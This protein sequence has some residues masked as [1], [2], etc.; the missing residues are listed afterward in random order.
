MKKISLKIPQVSRLLVLLL[1]TEVQIL[2][3]IKRVGL[4]IEIHLWL[5]QVI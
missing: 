3:L 2:A 1:W 4:Y 5:L